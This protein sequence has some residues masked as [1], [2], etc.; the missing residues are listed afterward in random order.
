GGFETRGDATWA[1]RNDT[2]SGAGNNGEA[3]T[4]R[5][6]EGP[7]ELQVWVKTVPNGNG[8]V[9]FYHDGEKGIEVQCFNTPD[10]TNPTGSIYG[11]APAARVVARD[12]EWYLV[13]IFADGPRA[14]VLVNGEKVSETNALKPPYR[15]RIGFQLHTPASVIH[16]RG[17]RIKPAGDVFSRGGG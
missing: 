4:K 14:M 6:F 7:F 2:L 9:F 3:L 5:E 8:G 16:Y 15:G 17:V 10:S 12:E 11:I 13:Q 1:V